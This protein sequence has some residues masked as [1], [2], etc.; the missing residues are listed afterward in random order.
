MPLPD[1]R[2][3]VERT[4][5]GGGHPWT[6]S[7]PPPE[8]DCPVAREVIADSLALQKRH[9]NPGAGPAL[10]RYA[11]GFEKVWGHLDTVAA[12]AGGRS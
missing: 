5:F 9:L 3:F 11:D 6:A 8:A 1:Q 10:D 4:G 7:A 12:L 2:V